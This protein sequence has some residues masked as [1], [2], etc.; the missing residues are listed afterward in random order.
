VHGIL[1]ELPKR[2]DGNFLESF[3]F[4]HFFFLR[5]VFVVGKQRMW[6][7]RWD[8]CMCALACAWWMQKVR[9]RDEWIRMLSNTILIC[10][11]ECSKWAQNWCLLHH[12]CGLLLQFNISPISLQATWAL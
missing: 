12:S 11:F 1:C 8:V 7:W 5:V 10:F 4:S 2:L 6:M 9:E 3:F